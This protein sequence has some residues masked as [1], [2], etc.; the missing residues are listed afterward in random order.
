MALDPDDPRPPYQQV[1][2]HLRASILTKRFGPGDK[3]PS[4][5]ELAK[6]YGVARM[7]IQQALRLLRDEG[8]TVSRQGSGVFVRAR[9]ERPVGLR[10]YLERAFEAAHVAI[11][12]AGLSGE[13]LAGAIT[14][15]LDK[16]RAGRLAPQSIRVRA[17]V[18]DTTAPWALP[19]RAEDLSDDPEFRARMAGITARSIAAVTDAV[20][21]LAD[22]G[23]VKSASTEVR[24]HGATPLFKLYLL[25]HEDVFFGFYPVTEHTVAIK[26]T[27]HVV[28]DLMGKDTT[29]FHHSVDDVTSGGRQYVEQAQLWFES[30]WSTV[31]REYDR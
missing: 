19:C 6:H 26:G 11:D 5:P 29:L 16:I 21:E 25:N 4:G 30:V 8:L 17:L 23:L 10:P 15:P 18:P 9:T 28:Y 27:P 1:A 24:V 2:H 3:L 13:T 31:S 7:T 14:E 22:L 12:F 20:G